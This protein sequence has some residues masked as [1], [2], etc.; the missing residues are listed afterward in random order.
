MLIGNKP[1]LSC[2]VGFCLSSAAGRSEPD[3]KERSIEKSSFFIEVI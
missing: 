3:R 2:V 1:G